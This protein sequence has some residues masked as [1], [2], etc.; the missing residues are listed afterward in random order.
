MFSLDI[1]PLHIYECLRATAAASVGKWEAA[2]AR[3]VRV[4]VQYEYCT[5]VGRVPAWADVNSINVVPV[6]V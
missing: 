4:L 6:P 3:P 1:D 5:A 2:E